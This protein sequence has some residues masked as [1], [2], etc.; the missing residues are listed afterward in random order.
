MQIQIQKNGEYF[1]ADYD[2]AT[3]TYVITGPA[4]PSYSP[5][6]E[7]VE[8]ISIGLDDWGPLLKKRH[9][10]LL[11]TRRSYGQPSTSHQVRVSQP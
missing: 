1:T 3:Q 7:P 8:D 11:M 5:Y 10:S 2:M 4:T 9:S 6:T